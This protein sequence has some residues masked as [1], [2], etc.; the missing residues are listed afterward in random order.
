MSIK[1]PKNTGIK[2][3]TALKLLEGNPGKRPIK[4]NEVKPNPAMPKIP[5]W[6]EDDA[7]EEWE[8]IA[9]RLYNLGLLTAID[10]MTL[11]GYCQAYARW[12]A[13]EEVVTK[14]GM[15][16][17][18]ASGYTQQLPEATL[19]LKYMGA[20]RGFMAKFGMSPSDRVGLTVNEEE[21][22]DETSKYLSS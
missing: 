5:E 9:P 12:K 15:T 6:L 3:P 14:K 16:Y 10:D 7:K 1:N 21:E 18:T 20:M 22:K 13:A 11:A 8:R 4:N 19:A 2:K 17:T